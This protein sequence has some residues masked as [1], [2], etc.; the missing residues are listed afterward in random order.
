MRLPVS[1]EASTLGDTLSADLRTI[2]STLSAGFTTPGGIEQALGAIGRL[3][4]NLPSLRREL[5]SIRA[6]IRRA[7]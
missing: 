5:R 1:S 7:A 4:D 6:G 3:Q 2:T